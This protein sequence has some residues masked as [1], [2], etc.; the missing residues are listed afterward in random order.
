MTDMEG[1]SN[2]RSGLNLPALSHR[3]IRYCSGTISVVWNGNVYYLWAVFLD[4]TDHHPAKKWAVP[5][6]CRPRLGSGLHQSRP[7]PHSSNLSLR[8]TC[9]WYRCI[10]CVVAVVVADVVVLLLQEV[11]TDAEIRDTTIKKLNPKNIIF[12][13]TSFSP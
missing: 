4:V 3:P 5:N 1:E 6:G 8:S 2:R 12:F 9:A 10:G 7:G 13:F 11:S